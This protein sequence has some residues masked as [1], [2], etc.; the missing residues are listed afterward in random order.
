LH[1]NLFPQRTLGQKSLE[2][3]ELAVGRD[4]NRTTKTVTEGTE[5]EV[6]VAKHTAGM[7]AIGMKKWFERRGKGRSV[8]EGQKEELAGS[9]RTTQ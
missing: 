4:R 6:W 2:N 1:P 9:L 8:N 3:R 7:E 5:L